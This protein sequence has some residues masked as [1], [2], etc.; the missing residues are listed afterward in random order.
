MTVQLTDDVHWINESYSLGNDEQIHLS[1]YLVEAGDRAI[2]IDTGSFYHREEIKKQI[3]DT[4]GKLDAII[5]SH[6]DVPHAGNLRDF[7]TTWDD[8]TL[9]SGSGAP[10]IQGYPIHDY[11]QCRIGADM[12]IEGRKFSF[13]DPPLADRNHT[14]WIYDQE[15]GVLVTAD[16]FGNHHTPGERDYL[17][18]DFDDCTPTDRIYE[19]HRTALRWLRFVNPQKVQ[20]TL[21]RMFSTYD[22]SYVAPIHGNPIVAGDIPEYMDRLMTS[23][24][25]ISESAS[26]EAAVDDQE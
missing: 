1:V 10:E 22:I 19:F 18:S 9:V 26:A 3:I 7:D 4:V 21:D 15:S 6:G 17:S 5:L 25:R 24:S 14:V 2:L 20:T 12:T 16:G 13:I 11:R 23:I 8:I